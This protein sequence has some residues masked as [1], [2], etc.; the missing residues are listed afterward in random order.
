MTFTVGDR[1]VHPMHGAGVIDSIETCRTDGVERD[2]YVMRIPMGDILVKIPKET[3]DAIGV[4]PVM[5]A[6]QAR[7]LLDNISNI[8]VEM[9]QNWN[10]RYRENM[11]K[12]CSGDL[13]EV[14]AV[15][16]SLSARADG[17]GLSTGERKMLNSAKQ[18]LLSELVLSQN[19]TYDEAQ[20][21]LERAL[22]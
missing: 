1:I 3:S 18:I 14:A 17:R 8:H 5:Q 19:F 12:L 16:K 11:H 15:I 21:Q 10:K 4:R 20:Q 13:L 9:T 6:D 2:Y 7:Q 22:G